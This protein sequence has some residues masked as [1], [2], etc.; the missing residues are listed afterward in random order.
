M[1][2]WECSTV[3]DPKQG[4][5]RPYVVALVSKFKLCPFGFAVLEM[6]YRSETSTDTEKRF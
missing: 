5:G 3:V 4:Q 1:I 2:P 6:N